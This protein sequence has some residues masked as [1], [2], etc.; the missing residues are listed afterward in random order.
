MR[1]PTSLGALP[2]HVAHVHLEVVDDSRQGVHELVRRVHEVGG[3][4]RKIT[5]GEP[6]QGRRAGRAVYRSASARG[7]ARR[8]G[9]LPRSRTAITIVSEH[10]SISVASWWDTRKN[11][12]SP[13][14]RRTVR[15]RCVVWTVCCSICA[16]RSDPGSRPQK[17]AMGR[18]WRLALLYRTVLARQVLRWRSATSLRAFS[19]TWSCASLKPLLLLV[20]PPA[21]LPTLGFA[22]TNRGRGCVRPSFVAPGDSCPGCS[23]CTRSLIGLRSRESVPVRAG[24]V[25]TVAGR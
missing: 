13:A 18:R 25:C 16:F 22:A 5:Q 2:D 1:L 7:S 24:N 11:R 17:A 20:L 19:S 9:P 21:S 12:S 3:T 14:A 4:S 10:A 23:R 6:G 8:G 15:R